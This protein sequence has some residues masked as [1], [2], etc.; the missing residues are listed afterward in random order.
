MP[1]VQSVPDKVDL[2][3]VPIGEHV[4]TLVEVFPVESD[5]IYGKQKDPKAPDTKTRWAWRF[6]SDAQ[7][8]DGKP[9][10]YVHWTGVYYGDDRAGLTALLDFI[11][12]GV[13]VED[14]KK[15]NTDTLIGKRFKVAIKTRVNKKGVNVPAAM[16]FIPVT[17]SAPSSFDPDEIPF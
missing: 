11:L 14:K 12:P 2:R 3:P 1:V 10:E 5:N 6:E 13:S 4:L 7:D 15:V 17:T 8:E 9:Y 16:Y